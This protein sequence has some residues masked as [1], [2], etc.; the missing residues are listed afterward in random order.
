MSLANN[1]KNRT[2]SVIGKDE[3]IRS[4]LDMIAEQA[5]EGK[6]D[7]ITAAGTEEQ[8]LWLMDKG[9][10]VEERDSEWIVNWRY[11]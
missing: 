2:L 9:F 10:I 7:L 8:M 6:F 5:D 4:L 11:T 1:M 3:F